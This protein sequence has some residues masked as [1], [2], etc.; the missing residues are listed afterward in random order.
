MIHGPGGL[1]SGSL[2]YSGRGRRS[3]FGG[4]SGRGLSSTLT[5][6]HLK[7]SEALLTSRTL[8]L[9]VAKGEPMR[10]R[11]TVRGHPPTAEGVAV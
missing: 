1:E 5:L 6:A 10:V 3:W 2:S 11:S 8:I 7:E 9:L 4:S